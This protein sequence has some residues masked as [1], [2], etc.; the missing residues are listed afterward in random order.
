MISPL[1]EDVIVNILSFLPL[2][3][4]ARTS[5]LSSQWPELWKHASNHVFVRKCYADKMAEWY[6]LGHE[7]HEW[8]DSVLKSHKAYLKRIHNL[9]CR[10]GIGPVC[11]YQMVRTREFKASSE[12][13]AELP[14]PRWKGR[15]RHRRDIRRD[16]L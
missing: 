15:S 5:V 13:G 4:A 10:E 8:V 11:H 1:P 2:N 16:Q 6:G 3:E 7:Y 12:I 9:H 14:I